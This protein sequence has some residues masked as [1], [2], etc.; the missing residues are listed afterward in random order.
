MMQ[1]YM[2]TKENY[3]D[4]L[5]FYRLGDFYELFFEDAVIAS[6]ALDLTLTGRNCGLDQKAPMCGVPYHAVDT[7]L[8]KLVSQG[9]KVAICEQLTEPAPGTIVS[10]DVTRVVTPGTVMESSILE[11]NKNNY[12]ASVYKNNNSIGIAYADIST[13]EFC[14]C[15]F[16]NNAYVKA[17]DCL[18]RVKPTE[19]ICND[20][21]SNAASQINSS[22]FGY[23]PV[24]S[25]YN[26]W[27]Y[28]YENALDM[29]KKQLNVDSLA[30]FDYAQKYSAISAA[31]ALISYM[32]DTQKRTLGH[33]NSIVLIKDAEYM[34]LDNT[35]CRN[36]ELTETLREQ[37]KRGSLLGVID[38]TKTSM[39]SRLI[40]NWLLQP[41]QD[42]DAINRRLNL[43]ELLKNNPIVLDSI[44]DKL[45]NICDIQ[46]LAGKISYGS[47]MPRDCISLMNS[48]KIIPSVKA[49]ID[50]L[51]NTEI[52]LLLS[53]MDKTTEL[54]DFISKSINE[55][56]PAILSGGGFIKK[57]YN[58]QLDELRDTSH[59]AQKWLSDLEN[60]EREKTG[61]K[62]LKIGY[63]RVFGY[64]I[65]INKSQIDL[66]P[67]NYQRRQTI[68]NHERYITPE[69]KEIEDKI[70]GA[71]ELSIKL[72]Q[73]LYAKIK[74]YMM[75]LVSSIQSVAN[76]IAQLD[77][78][79]S[80]ATIALKN[81]YCRPNINKD[82]NCIKIEDGRHPVVEA[83]L[84]SEMFIP[85]DTYLTQT[86][87]TMIITGP[88]MAGK[89]TYMR[90]VALITLMAHIG[91]FVP[92]K[93]ADICI[94]DRI[95]TRIGASDDLSY[96]QSTFMV[97]MIEVAN[98]LSNATQNSLLLLDEVGRGTSTYDGLSIAWAVIEHIVNN[99]KAKTLF[100]THYHELTQLEGQLDGVKNYRISVKEYDNN[101]I[102]LRK[103]VRGGAN[104]SFGI[105]VASLAGIDRKIVDRARVI[106]HNVE[107]VGLETVVATESTTKTD[108][109]NEVINRLKDLDINTVSPMVAFDILNELSMKAKK[110]K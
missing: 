53:E 25:K 21:M 84:R 108:S 57:G 12:I 43:V 9:F 54:S 4:C 32:I 88:N 34:Y 35:T 110:G 98:I 96:G 109:N 99:I 102:F 17:N 37:K 80:L 40:R 24:F 51:N 28:K 64:Y 94:V 20:A 19:I 29:V 44:S 66:V 85:N 106:L 74:E 27:A 58:S 72:E 14:V 18:V 30:R 60:A 62:T 56:S 104:R 100:A 89:S 65:E 39:G 52:S 33:I 79:C 73:E 87:H 26:D 38:K 77:C 76:D 101:I 68:A 22:K 61:I 11:D 105:E 41:L 95:F 69:L 70:L 46:R 97:E 48:L 47:V 81:N 75:T 83:M 49:D 71:D 107:Q 82:V 55:E 6:K 93:S 42:S 50:R 103:I 31:G 78:L 86:D 59:S 10:R 13:G 3:K 45:N 91:S 23:L 2:L 15:E 36:L 92:A 5:L 67:Y 90:Q 1:Q 8:S 63:T 16:G 7:Y